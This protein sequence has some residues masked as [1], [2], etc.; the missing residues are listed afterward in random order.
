MFRSLLFVGLLHLPAIAQVEFSGVYPHL[1]M[2]NQ[3]G[4]CGTGGVVPWAGK[5]WVMTYAPHQPKGSTDKLYEITPDLKQTVRPESIGGTPANRMIHEESQ[6][7]FLGPYIIDAQGGLRTIPYTTMFGR[8]TG[9]ARHLTDP[10]GKILYASMEEG[11]CEVDVKTL[12][13]K[14]LWIDEQLQPGG[15]NKKTTSE[16]KEGPKANLPGY[17][18]KGFYSAQGRYVYANNGE[19]GGEARVNPRIPSGVL[20][21]WDGKA[22]QWTIVR[23]NQFTEITGPGGIMGKA[24]SPDAPLWAVGWDHR[25]LILM[26][27]HGGKWHAYRLPKGSHSYDG[28]HGWNTEWPRI[29][30]IGEKDFLMTMHGTFW[31]FPKDFTPQKSAGIT[32]RSNYLKVIGDFCA[33]QGKV[34][35][36][37][38][39]TAKSEFLNKRKA[40]GEIAAPR[41]QSNLWF[42]KHERL[43]Q[44]GAVLGRGALWL[45]DEVKAGKT[46]DPYLFSGYQQR[47]MHVSHT[48]STPLSLLLEVDRKGDGNWTKLDTI[49]AE[50][51]VLTTKTFSASEQAA[52][53]RVTPL[54]DAKKLSVCFS[55]R[56]ASPHI[57]PDETLFAG[58]AASGSKSARGGSIRA[59]D[60]DALT[61]SM[62]ATD[63]EGKET[64]YY[65][66]GADMKLTSQTDTKAAQ[67]HRQHCKMMEKS[68]TVDEASALVIDDKGRRWRFPRGAAAYANGGSFGNARLAREVATERDLL[69]LCGTF[70]ELPAENAGGFALARPVATHDRLIHDFCSWRGLLLM[71]GI[72]DTK[73]DNRHIIR[74]DDGKAALWAGVIDDAWKLGKPRGEGGPWK[75]TM[76]QQ[77]AAS[78]PYLMTGYDRKSLTLVSDQNTTILVEVD[79]SGWGDWV[80]YQKMPLEAGKE[81]T[82]LFGEAFSA[83]WVRFTSDKDAV[84]SAQLR[85]E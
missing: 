50:S 24:D 21:E 48:E 41:S 20:A 76:V 13:V 49:T 18:G 16:D 35:L 84:V 25:S 73:T 65:T 34:V 3:E 38:D 66:M 17:H 70:Y 54:S 78:D 71:S 15:A 81:L 61:L 31:K 47:V 55:Y 63:A 10:A 8:H 30:D 26:C 27:L 33:W 46:S 79:I 72:D 77:G 74:S 7:L 11:I 43:D 45:N 42:V 44:L 57:K 22:D 2:S 85:Y 80:V 82:H 58:V 51:G 60:N 39:D 28:A 6:Q 19:H 67:F 5:L 37:C 4:E 29:R 83:Y 32:P 64:G 53:I 52:W 12:A 40:K 75:N 14:Y 69:N 62:M 59:A 9:N 68:F 23:R 56:N 1:V 36:G